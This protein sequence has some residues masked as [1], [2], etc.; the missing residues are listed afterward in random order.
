MKTSISIWSISFC[1]VLLAGIPAIAAPQGPGTVDA[2]KSPERP[3]AY[4]F[5]RAP[6]RSPLFSN[7]PAEPAVGKTVPQAPPGYVI[8]RAP[9]GEP[10]FS[11]CPVALVND[12]PLTLRDFS[13]AIAS[14]H[15][16]M[17]GGTQA[18]RIDYAQVMRRLI[19]VR[20]A[21]EEARAIGLDVLPE[22]KRDIEAFADRTLRD[23]VTS[24]QVENIKADEAEVQKVYRASIKEIKISAVSFKEKKDAEKFEAA[25]KAG[26]DFGELLKQVPK[27]ADAEVSAKGRFMKEG[28]VEPQMRAAMSSMK[29]G[30]ISPVIRLP[31][32]FAVVKLEDIRSVED[33]KALEEARKEVLG[34]MQFQALKKFNESLA[35]KYVKL[36]KK[37]FTSLDFESKGIPG[38]LALL[39]DKRV[40]AQVK[41]HS[42]VTVAEYANAVKDAFFHDIEGEIKRKR[43]NKKKIE[44]Y[45]NF[46]AKKLLVIA[47]REKGMDKTAEFKDAVK[48]HRDGV[49]Y[50]VF[51]SKVIAPG[52][53]MTN[54]EMKRYYDEHIS[55]Y[56]SPERIRIS[57]LIFDKNRRSDAEKAV[58]E[59]RKGTDFTWVKDNAGG[60]GQQER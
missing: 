5:L 7:C 21:L 53:K 18:A 19:D 17:S 42:P 6:L 58:E 4:I 30:D 20:L 49:I 40:L 31:L 55:D 43:I 52:I 41:G 10:R 29:A 57:S 32:G 1:I 3:S 25:A 34:R 33:P 48:E 54:D 37:L 38:F 15:E 13:N 44:I 23:M 56:S 27:G 8:L 16:G 50:S 28:N 12:K 51:V 39:K 2:G 9:I 26:K 35:K 47:A 36:N 59:L 60:A 22:V 45:E 11:D 46:M 24:A 14:L